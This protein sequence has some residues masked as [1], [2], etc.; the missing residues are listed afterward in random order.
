[1]RCSPQ[2]SLEIFLLFHL[3]SVRAQEKVPW[4]DVGARERFAKSSSAPFERTGEKDE[5]IS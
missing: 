2:Q 4:K 5:Q 1:M 3:A